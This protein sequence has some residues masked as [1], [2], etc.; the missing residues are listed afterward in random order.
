MI[1]SLPVAFVKISP[2][3]YITR[4]EW[5]WFLLRCKCLKPL[6]YG[7]DV[8]TVLDTFEYFPHGWRLERMYDTG[9]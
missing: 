8:F 1:Q 3:S 9:R 2:T 5:L 7:A 6:Q 4:D